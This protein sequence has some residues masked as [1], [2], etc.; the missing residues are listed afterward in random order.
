MRGKLLRTVDA[1]KIQVVKVNQKS[2]CYKVRIVNSRPKCPLWRRSDTL[3]T[4][5]RTS[6]LLGTSKL[7]YKLSNKY[8]NPKH[9]FQSRFTHSCGLVT[10]EACFSDATGARS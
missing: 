10:E 8:A 6:T 4:P 5:S 9:L 1:R 2:W 7:F 3:Q